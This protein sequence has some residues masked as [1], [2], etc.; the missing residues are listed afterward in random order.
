MIAET[1]K[2]IIA[3][4][5]IFYAMQVHNILHFP[6]VDMSAISF[7]MTIHSLIDYQSDKLFAED[8]EMGNLIDEYIA[9]FCKM[10]QIEADV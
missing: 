9:Y 8:N 3:T 7:A 5:H 2:M 6:D 1:E 10:Y 4:K